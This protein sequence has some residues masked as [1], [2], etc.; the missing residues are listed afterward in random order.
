MQLKDRPRVFLDTETTG[1]NPRTHEMIEF[2]GLKVY[3]DGE[4]EAL[5]MKITPERIE[6]ASPKA[7]E[8]NGYTEEAWRDSVPMS[9]AIPQ[10][11]E[12]V[13]GCVL[14]GHNI[15]FDF[16]FIKAAAQKHDAG[17]LPYHTVDTV[18]LAYEHLAP[19]GLSKMSLANVCDYLGISNANAH[20]AMVDVIRCKEVFDRLTAGDY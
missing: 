6:D 18:T 16:N 11:V 15:K 17:G 8:I 9:E 1:L 12:F 4:V 3:P 14:V 5:E 10:I 2:A 7:L 13:K 20:T 19:R